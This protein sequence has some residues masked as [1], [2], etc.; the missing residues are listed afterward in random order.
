MTT[1]F[2]LPH[3]LIFEPSHT[4][5]SG[6][7][8]RWSPIGNQKQEWLGVVSG[9]ILKV[10][11]SVVSLLGEDRK[12]KESTEELVKRFFSL[13]DDLEEISLSFPK[14]PYLDSALSQFSGLRL[15][16]QD[17]WECLVSFLCSINCNI[18]SIRAKI[19]NLCLKF[20][21]KIE[22]DLNIEAYS[23]PEA[24]ALATAKK[25]ELLACKLGFRWKYVSFLA[26]LIAS[27]Q[28]DLKSLS[29]LGYREARE[30][31]IS[32]ISGNTFGVGPKI[33][34]CL[35]LFSSRK[36]EAFPIDV[37]ILRCI[38]ENYSQL[39]PH[40]GDQ[41]RP[42]GFPEHLSLSMYLRLGDN[43]R[44]YFGKYAGYAQQYLYMKR[45]TEGQR[46]AVTPSL[47]IERRLES[48]C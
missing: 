17:P 35:L 25:H 28:L 10:S 36:L 1:Q 8:F 41:N 20:G 5:E 44:S 23:F 2:P 13:G 31:L 39:L 22:T 40:G 11:K 6:Q 26:K 24:S 9:R 14:D 37:W 32:E 19:E 33:A 45:R 7:V 30:L 3:E 4:F 15:L 38:R 12:L 47:Q 21:R 34:D 42:Q 48:Q 18:P 43:L 46:P 29:S 27:G 16:T